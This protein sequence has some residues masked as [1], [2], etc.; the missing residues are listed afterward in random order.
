MASQE[1]QDHL[2]EETQGY[3]LSQPKQ[4]LAEYQNM[5]GVDNG[6]HGLHTASTCLHNTRHRH[7]S[8]QLASSWSTIV[9]NEG[10]CSYATT[11]H[12]PL[13]HPIFI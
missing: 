8:T 11:I 1:E 5:V 10:I 2:P 13:C 7:F 6:Q 9:D 3:K 12:S 4:S